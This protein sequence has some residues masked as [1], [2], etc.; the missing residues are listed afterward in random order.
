MF[1]DLRTYS[2]VNGNTLDVRE[3]WLFVLIFLVFWERK[4]S[5]ALAEELFK[6]FCEKA[7]FFCFFLSEK[8]SS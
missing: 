2:F 6:I 5:N 1:S 7:D 4:G 8:V 3:I